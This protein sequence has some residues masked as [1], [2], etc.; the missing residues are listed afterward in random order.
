[1]ITVQCRRCTEFFGKPTDH[2]LPNGAVKE[3]LVSAQAGN[4]NTVKNNTVCLYTLFGEDSYSLSE[5][6]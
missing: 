4:L 5:A 1:M 6:A 2:K 3:I